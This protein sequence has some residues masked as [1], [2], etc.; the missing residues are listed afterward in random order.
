MSNKISNVNGFDFAHHCP[1]QR[2][3]D[4]SQ[5]SNLVLILVF[6]IWKT[7]DTWVLFFILTFPT[8]FFFG[9]V[10][11]EGLFFLLFA[12]TLYFLKKENY[13]LVSLFGQGYFVG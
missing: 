9:A 5:I 11:T 1:E 4:K 6:L 10:Y 12:L 3:T 2:R 7:F 8:S 13:W